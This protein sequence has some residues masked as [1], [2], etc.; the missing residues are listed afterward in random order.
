MAK[1]IA[2]DSD[3]NNTRVPPA[4]KQKK[5]MIYKEGIKSV[6][7]DSRCLDNLSRLFE[8][9]SQGC[10]AACLIN[11]TIIIADN[12][13]HEGTQL[14]NNAGARVQ[15]IRKIMNYFSNLA[16]QESSD[17]DIREKIFKQVCVEKIKGEAKGNILLDQE[18]CAKI[19][20][21]VL[22]DYSK[23]K[24]WHSS[25]K[26]YN[27]AQRSQVAAAY[28]LAE[29]VARDFIKIEQFIKKCK[30]DEG[31][32]L[33]IA[34]KGEENKKIPING[35]GGVLKKHEGL[36]Q[37]GKDPGYIILNIDQVGVH[38]EAKIIEYLIFTGV[39]YNTEMIK[40]IYVGISKLCCKGCDTFIEAVNEILH[41]EIE[42]SLYTRGAHKLHL[43][44]AQP[45]IC[46]FQKPAETYLYFE[47]K[48]KY[49]I[50]KGVT[51]SKAAKLVLADEFI[52]LVESTHVDKLSKAAPTLSKAERGMN[53]YVLQRA[54]SSSTAASSQDE[55]GQEKII[56][57]TDHQF[58]E[59]FLDR[60]GHLYNAQVRKLIVTPLN[61][62]DELYQKFLYINLIIAA[63]YIAVANDWCTDLK[64]YLITYFNQLPPVSITSTFIDTK[65]VLH[66]NEIETITEGTI[67][68]MGSHMED[69]SL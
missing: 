20:G 65:D 59:A 21:E 7:K 30:N 43:S 13:I 36:V 29:T 54:F 9:D 47:D 8:K 25:I 56:N 53:E 19:A 28:Y 35:A 55:E 67:S 14:G 16:K 48:N 23:H 12:D 68:L 18:T 64:Y 66:N 11:E 41:P 27:P 52:Y 5:Y 17:E 38:A 58:Y 37:L 6:P 57:L 22:A 42:M 24:A 26:A 32:S 62:R 45:M 33:I 51:A 63:N 46:N 3:I 50:K 49:C 34:F 10:A 1:R 31:N 40:K 44:W 2:S 39:L 61:A 15:L 69:A 4:K 60:F